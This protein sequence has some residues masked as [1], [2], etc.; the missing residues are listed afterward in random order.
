MAARATSLSLLDLDLDTLLSLLSACTAQSLSCLARTCKAFGSPQLTSLAWRCLLQRDYDVPPK[1]C[2]SSSDP[3]SLYKLLCVGRVKPLE[4]RGF[5]TDGG[6]DIADEQ[7]QLP[8]R[9]DGTVSLV[10]YGP[11]HQAKTFWVDN[12]FRSETDCCTYCSDV[13][14]NIVVAGAIEGP[15]GV[16][17]LEGRAAAAEQRTFLIERLRRVAQQFWGWNE[18]GFGGLQYAATET[19]EQALIAA[20]PIPQMR[21]L[22]LSDLP[23]RDRRAAMKRLHDIAMS[24]AQRAPEPLVLAAVQVPGYETLLVARSSFKKLRAWRRGRLGRRRVLKG[25]DPAA[26]QKAP[27]EAEVE[28]GEQEDT[29][30]PSGEVDQEEELFD[31]LNDSHLQE[32]GAGEEGEEGEEGDEGEEGLLVDM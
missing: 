20:W 10:S 32:Q 26:P 1:R 25:T 17:S 2:A 4:V 31:L 7:A 13:R 15:I 23:A 11:E 30:D 9:K 19:L 16:D 28:E 22:L 24:A 8:K 14:R 5:F 27:S 29:L 6:V 3:R 12:A 21:Q 18:S